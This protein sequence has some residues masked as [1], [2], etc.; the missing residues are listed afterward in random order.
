MSSSVEWLNAKD[1]TQRL[2]F[3]K[4]LA[5]NYPGT[6]QEIL[7]TKIVGDRMFLNE[8]KKNIDKY[9]GEP[10]D[11]I[12]KVIKLRNAW[13]KKKSRLGSNRSTLSIDVTP[14]L[15]AQFTGLAKGITHAEL[16]SNMLDVFNTG[17]GDVDIFETTP[18]K[19]ERRNEIS[20]LQQEVSA[21]K[22]E[23]DKKNLDIEELNKKL[24]VAHKKTP[25][26]KSEEVQHEEISL[27]FEERLT[28]IASEIQLL[29]NNQTT[30]GN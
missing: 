27:S 19:G 18:Q 15:F 16:L 5:K 8:F 29:N 9:W 24:E 2:W 22:K 4:H 14:E 30:S 1:A 17:K 21:L 10:S 3:R 28:K 13:Y 23:L 25:Q 20:E 12:Q 6:Y 26:S 7:K 11:R